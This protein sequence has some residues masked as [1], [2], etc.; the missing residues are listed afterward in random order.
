M[1]KKAVDYSK[2]V[3]YKIVCNDVNITDCYVGH[4][5]NFTK[6]KNQHKNNCN[7]PSSNSYNFNVYKF[8]RENGGWINWSMVMVEEYNC[9]SNIQACAKERHYIELLKA[10]LNKSIPNRTIIEYRKDNKEIIAKK[11]KEFYSK[12]KEKVLV[13]CKEYRENNRDKIIEMNT[14]YQINHKTQRLETQQRYRD[15]NR[16]KLKE[17]RDKIKQESN[18]KRRTKYNCVCGSIINQG[19]KSTHEK[20]ITHKTYIEQQQQ[21]EQEQQKE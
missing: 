5:T 16:D 10:T 18:E 15:K 4:T 21:D 19:N 8:I 7:N 11:K 3:I 9:S 13:K 12:N 14:K 17:Y 1:P 2:C 20:T 6:R